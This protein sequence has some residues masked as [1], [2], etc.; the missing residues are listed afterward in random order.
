MFYF[1]SSSDSDHSQRTPRKSRLYYRQR[2]EREHHA[3]EVS[4]LKAEI[5]K[6]YKLVGN[7]KT[8]ANGDDSSGE[9]HAMNIGSDVNLDSNNGGG[10]AAAETIK[11][12]EA[13]NTLTEKLR[14]LPTNERVAMVQRVTLLKKLKERRVTSQLAKDVGLDRRSISSV[15]KGPVMWPKKSENRKERVLAFLQLPDHSVTLAGKK[16]TMTVNCKK[17]QKVVLTQFLNPLNEEYNKQNPEKL[18]SLSFFRNIRRKAKEAAQLPEIIS[19]QMRKRVQVTYGD[20]EEPKGAMKLRPVNQSMPFR[21][22]F[23]HHGNPDHTSERKISTNQYCA[24]L[25]RFSLVPV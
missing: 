3:A 12:L 1:Q 17:K 21:C 9:G 20:P 13:Y 2:L 19:F 6:L 24:S 15:N 4:A 10:G 18:V 14:T 22:Y 23:G 5:E 16:D 25:F 8:P 7:P 11:K